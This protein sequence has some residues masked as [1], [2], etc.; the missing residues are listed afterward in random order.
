MKAL[1]MSLKSETPCGFTKVTK[2]CKL[3]NDIVTVITINK[4]KMTMELCDQLIED[5]QLML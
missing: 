1:P 4:V 2:L 3:M 5:N